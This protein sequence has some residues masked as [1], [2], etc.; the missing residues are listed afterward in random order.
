MP[1]VF[2]ILK[3]L[4]LKAV[5]LDEKTNAM[6]EGYFVSFRSVGLPIHQEDFDNPYSPLGSNL[7]K[8]I[9]IPPAAD[10]AGAPKTASAQ[11]DENKVAAANIG[12]SMQAYLNTFL[13]IDDKLQMNNQY[14]VMP[15]S[16]KVSDSWWAIIT[17][18]NGI[19]TD[20]VIND[21]MKAAY[22][23][24][25]AKLIDAE[26]NPTAHYQAYMDRED[27]YK[28]KVR[29]WNK[30][31][32]AAFTDP[33]RLQQWPIEGRLYHDD[34]DEAWD[35]W[36]S[37][38]FKE[39]IES[40]LA[41][42]AAQGTDP[43]IA[44]DFPA[45]KRFN[46]SLLEFQNVGQIPYTVMLPNSWAD[47]SNDDGWNQYTSSDFHTESHYQASSTSYGGGGGFNIGFWSAGASFE[48]DAVSEL[49]EHAD[50]RPR[51]FVQ[52]LRGRHQTPVARHVAAE[53]A[54]LVPHG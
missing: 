45:K 3:D 1:D 28:D 33:M 52:L 15:G 19:P 30:A 51:G 49:V 21:S 44:L 53:S 16:S 12:K 24:A 50:R 13:L 29:A 35:R 9:P 27:Q 54:E 36:S 11:M 40:A 26:G 47:P 10:P 5:G 39:E 14:A 37:F 8:D 48:H 17:G 38:G 25:R 31:Y 7:A 41:T 6:Q 42:L 43:A 32:A 2:K 34:A 4:E 22:D 23:A 46:N 20:S 18:A